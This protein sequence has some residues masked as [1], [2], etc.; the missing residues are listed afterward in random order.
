MDVRGE[1]RAEPIPNKL[2]HVDVI[3]GGHVER[4][5]SCCMI[6]SCLSGS[7]NAEKGS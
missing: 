1:T 2:H 6:H 4:D 3:L 7:K 5:V